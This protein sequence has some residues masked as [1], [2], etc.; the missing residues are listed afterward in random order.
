MNERKGGIAM[1]VTPVLDQLEA[2]GTEQARKTYRNHGVRGEQYGVSYADL[3]KLKNKIKI[4]DSLA[5]QLWSS[6]VHDARILALMIADP[7]NA[8]SVRLDSWVCDLANYVLT[9]AFSRYV[10]QTALAREKM[11]QWTQSDDEWVGSTGWNILGEL[12]LNDRNLPDDYFERYLTQIERDIH[13]RKNRVR[14]AMNNA[15][16][17]MGG[18][19]PRLEEK[20]L[21]VATV[22]GK[23][24]VDHGNT[25]CKTPDA[26][27][28]IKILRARQ[29]S[30]A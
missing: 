26:A 17:A 21:A 29:I 16:I 3:K 30:K 1:S 4:N 15:L 25:N 19:N 9:D 6:G 7:K 18:R 8:D 14:H 27:T 24:V 10:A 2:L 22:V 5:T 13:D 20:T 23:V 12:A 11:E 28:S